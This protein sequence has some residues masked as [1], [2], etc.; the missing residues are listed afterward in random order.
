M[1]LHYLWNKTMC[2]SGPT[3]LTHILITG[4]LFLNLCFSIRFWATPNQDTL[5]LKKI[6]HNQVL[7]KKRL[8][9]T[10][11]SRIKPKYVSLSETKS[12]LLS[13]TSDAY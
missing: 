4:Q 1:H 5:Y 12:G 10:W 11:K 7:A 13:V 6:W 9:Q 3:Q 8:Y 2:V